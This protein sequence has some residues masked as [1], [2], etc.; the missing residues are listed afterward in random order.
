MWGWHTFLSLNGQP[1]LNRLD[2]VDGLRIFP[3]HP[4]DTLEQLTT[5]LDVDLA[6]YVTRAKRDGIIDPFNGPLADVI[7]AG[8]EAL[9][10]T[11]QLDFEQWLR[12][13]QIDAALFPTLTDI[14]PAD[15]DSNPASSAVAW[16][17]GVWVS[18]GGL[19]IRHF[20]IPTVTV[21]MGLADDIGMPF[22][23]TFAGAAY[24][25]ATLVRLAT[26]F[27]A[28]RPRR[29]VPPRTPEL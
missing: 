10:E 19:A 4:L 22:G 17:N 1:G 15:A 16:R 6:E 8:I 27:E 18:T 12:D 9:E 5:D 24:S 29:I 13:N 11:R 25:D 26:M 3:R 28:L 14:A 21:P 20:G 2:Q 7:R 23:L